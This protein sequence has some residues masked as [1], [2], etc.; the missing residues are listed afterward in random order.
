MDPIVTV[1]H[2]GEGIVEFHCAVPGTSVT[3]KNAFLLALPGFLVVFVL[4]AFSIAEGLDLVSVW[5]AICLVL[6]WRK[7][8]QIKKES[9]LLMHDLGIQVKRSYVSGKEDNMF[10]ERSRLTSVVINEGVGFSA[11][12]YYLAF[13]TQGDTELVLAFS[14]L[15]P[16][17]AD[18]VAILHAARSVVFGED[19]PDWRAAFNS[20]HSSHPTASSSSSSQVPQSRLEA[21][22]EARDD[23]SSELPGFASELKDED[24]KTQ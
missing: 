18:L 6:L 22:A 4:W 10:V 3:W 16:R 12:T 14:E 2:H 20:L 1:E 9:L 7:M 17:I 15:I 23:A 13:I 5:I 8:G 19:A 21:S 24:K 11:V